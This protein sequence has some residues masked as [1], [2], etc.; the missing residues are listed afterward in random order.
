MP[1]A[2][3]NAADDHG[4]IS[5][6]TIAGTYDAARKVIDDLAALGIGYDDVIEV[7]EAEGVQKFEDSYAQ[8]AES[9]RGQLGAIDK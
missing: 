3:L 4:A 1:E 8:L 2:T 5:G 6:N 7:L 9:V